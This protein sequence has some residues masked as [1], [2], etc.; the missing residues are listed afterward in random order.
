MNS[1]DDRTVWDKHRST[2]RRINDRI[3]TRTINGISVGF[4]LGV[5]HCRE[6][7]G[8]HSSPVSQFRGPLDSWT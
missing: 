4:G 5:T 1:N 2:S 7:S 3:L 8:L 6:I